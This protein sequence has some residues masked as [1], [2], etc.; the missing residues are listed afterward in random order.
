M[1]EQDFAAARQLEVISVRCH[2]RPG[3]DVVGLRPGDWALIEH[4]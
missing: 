2:Q 4:N 1:A 3:L